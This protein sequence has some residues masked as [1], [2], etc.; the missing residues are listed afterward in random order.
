M[1]LSA[2]FSNS[3]N[4]STSSS[5]SSDVY[6]K[7]NKIMQSQNTVAPKLNA[8]LSAD[9]TML[10]GLGQLQSALASFQTLAQALAG[11][12][13][14][15]AA[16][17]SAANVL[18]ATTSSKSV[19]GSYN[20]TVNQLAQAQVL[21][22]KTQS[23]ADAAITLGNASKISFEFGTSSGSSFTAGSSTKTVDIPSGTNTL[24]GIATAINKAN[25]GVTAKVISTDTGYALTLSSP[26]GAANSMRVT[27]TGDTA[28]QNLVNYNP[29]GSKNLSQTTTAQDANLTINGVA[30]TS[31]SNTTSTAI[32]NITLKINAVG[33]SELVIA[34]GANQTAQNVSNLVDAYNALNDKLDALKTG[35]LKSDGSALRAQNQLK[36]LLSSSTSLEALAAAGVT[37]QDNGKLSIDKSKLQS[38]ISTDASSVSKLITNNGNGIADSLAKAIKSI[39]S[40][41][42]SITKKVASVNQDIT[43]INTQK[44]ALEK[45]LTAKANALVQYYSSQDSTQSTGTNQSSYS[46]F[47]YL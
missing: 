44:D 26:T 31:A 13:L 23:S 27:A 25:I 19:T 33:S 6:T 38:A 18:T 5:V 43:K 28:L 24:N 4:T 22:S 35:D 9:Q 21:Q 37:L 30:F 39:L 10:S 16:T 20:I 32:A 14:N 7:V 46:L 29:A 40:S 15:L 41:D 11:S 8:A 47:S 34:Q 12:G 3:A 2:Y 1:N 36:S 17:S 45:T 42:G